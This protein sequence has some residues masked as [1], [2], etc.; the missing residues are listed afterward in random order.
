MLF[1]VSAIDL[2]TFAATTSRDYHFGLYSE[3]PSPPVGS[4]QSAAKLTY[5]AQIA[6]L[7]IPKPSV[8]LPITDNVSCVTYFTFSQPS[9]SRSHE[10]LCEF[11]LAVDRSNHVP[12]EIGLV[13]V[14]NGGEGERD[15]LRYIL[16]DP[17]QEHDVATACAAFG[18][19]AGAERAGIVRMTRGLILV[20]DTLGAVLKHLLF[21]NAD[22]FEKAWAERFEFLAPLARH[23]RDGVG[24]V[25]KHSGAVV[26]AEW[27]PVGRDCNLAGGLGVLDDL[28]AGWHG[29]G[30][31]RPTA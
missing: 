29:L 31:G 23:Y 11:A 5:H 21:R 6:D 9:G 16:W 18:R 8:E 3:S 14:R 26:L 25:V 28:P 27:N 10:E 4:G 7:N 19:D 17:R 1:G 2:L 15:L 13:L 24:G 12:P 22:G 30:A 20:E